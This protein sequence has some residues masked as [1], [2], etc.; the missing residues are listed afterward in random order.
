MSANVYEVAGY[1]KGRPSRRRCLP[2][3]CVKLLIKKVARHARL[4]NFYSP[5]IPLLRSIQLNRIEF[6]SRLGSH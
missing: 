5:D 3:I 2:C 1:P 6:V 4:V